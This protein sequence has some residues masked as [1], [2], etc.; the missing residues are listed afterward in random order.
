M[1]GREIIQN[2]LSS[3][4][5]LPGV[6]QMFDCQQTIL[7]IGKAKNLKKRVSSYT[8]LDLSLRISRMVF[9]IHELKY[10]VTNSEAE[11]LLLE[12]TLIKKNKPKFNILLKDDKSFPY[13][14]ITKTH[15]Y[16]QISKF[17]GKPSK[18]DNYFGPF[19]SSG[20]VDI[21]ITEIQKIFKIRTCSDAYFSTRKRA[22]L[23]YQIKKCSAPC[24]NKVSNLE[25]QNLVQQAISFLSGKSKQLIENLKTEMKNHSENFEYEKAASVRDRI[26]AVQYIREKNSMSV[27][28]LSN[29]D[30]IGIVSSNAIFCVQVFIYRA[31]QNF[32]SN[33][34]F[35]INAENAEI[36]EVMM[37]FLGQFYQSKK[38]PEKII[39]NQDLAEEQEVLQ[40][41]LFKLHEL[42][43]KI[44]LPKNKEQKILMEMVENNANIAL[45]NKANKIHDIEE[46]LLEIQELFDLPNVP[47]RIEVYD[48]SHIMGQHAIGA[49]VVSGRNGFEKNEYRKFNIRTN[50]N[51]FGGD[52]YQMLREVLTRRFAKLNVNNTPDLIIV[53]GGKGHLSVV[54]EVMSC[55][56]L[57][58]KYVCM[59]KGPNRNKGEE[60]FH[61]INKTPFSL[62]NSNKT[63]QYLQVLRNEVHNFAIKSHR[64]K[65]NINT[66]K[67]KN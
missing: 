33:S 6:Y 22:C 8:K 58:I 63:M 19:A 13:I 14:K 32:G 24:V 36:K 48:N 46:R 20:Q 17:R 49:M 59:S 1:A 31:G 34:Y 53:D 35:P 47:E 9:S 39:I 67:I 64:Y 37:S 16:P 11:A 45:E 27:T 66:L 60:T 3:I 55:F 23:M 2:Q 40:D 18:D 52:D 56:D 42:K 57:K 12:A 7:Y 54:E 61:V 44:S 65:R 4:P 30:V 50:S 10:I 15:D 5:E 43:T 38:C 26:N 62:P 21:A 28:S 51:A 29:A 41:A 25:Y